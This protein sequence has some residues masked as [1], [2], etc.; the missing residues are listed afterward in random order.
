MPDIDRPAKDDRPSD[1]DYTSKEKPFIIRDHRQT[2][3]L[4]APGDPVPPIKNSGNFSL[5]A[6]TEDPQIAIWPFLVASA[7]LVLAVLPFRSYWYYLLLRLIV[8]SVAIYGG[9][10]AHERQ[11]NG[12]KWALGGVAVLFNPLVPFHLGKVVWAFVD[13]GTAALF[14]IAAW[15]LHQSAITPS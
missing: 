15:S 3:Y 13:L 8:C 9:T 4:D 2:L 12:W 11:R 10:M 14:C 1:T 5:I 6:S 7:C